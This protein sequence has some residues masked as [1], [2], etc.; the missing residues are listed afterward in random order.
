MNH[1]DTIR[2]WKDASYRNSLSDAERAQLP[3]N[4][5]GLAEVP[6]DLMAEVSGGGYSYF[7]GTCG[8]VCKALTHFNVCRLKA[9][10]RSS[11]AAASLKVSQ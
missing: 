7:T 10:K 9:P 11:V 3:A 8:R 2:A 6:Q 4:P 1:V 5:A